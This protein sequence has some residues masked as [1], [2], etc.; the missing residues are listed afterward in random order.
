MNNFSH[1]FPRAPFLV[2]FE[3]YL[4]RHN[5]E[6]V[7]GIIG[8]PVERLIRGKI[9]YRTAIVFRDFIDLYQFPNGIWWLSPQIPENYRSAIEISFY[10]KALLPVSNRFIRWF[11]GSGSHPRWQGIAW[12]TEKHKKVREKNVYSFKN[13]TASET[14]IVAAKVRW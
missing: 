14:K 9:F 1:S 3:R 4:A 10:A 7:L 12:N 11:P 5:G 13:S 6:L 2:V 8:S